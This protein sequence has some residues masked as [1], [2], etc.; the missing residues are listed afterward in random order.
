MLFRS[1]LVEHIRKQAEIGRKFI[2][3]QPVITDSDNFHL[4]LHQTYIQDNTIISETNAYRMLY[5]TH[6]MLNYL[7]T[8]DQD[9][10]N[11]SFA[12][13]QSMLKSCVKI[14]EENQRQRNAYFESLGQFI[15][16]ARIRIQ[17][18]ELY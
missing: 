4:Y 10:V 8:I 11:K 9:Y 13:F 16:K 15:S 7:Y 3:G 2:K 18:T 17:G 6:N 1:D 5:I 14:S 12:V